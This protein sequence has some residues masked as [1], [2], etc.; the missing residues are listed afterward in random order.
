MKRIVLA[1]CLALW[2]VSAAGAPA[3]LLALSKRISIREGAD[4]AIVAAVIEHESR[5]NP[6]AVGDAGRSV[7][8]MAL[9]DAGVGRGMTVAERMDPETNIRTGARALVRYWDRYGTIEQTLAAYNAGV[10]ALAQ[11]G[12]DWQL[13]YG[14]RVARGYVLPVL[15]TAERYR[16]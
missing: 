2:P 16:E 8:L 3:D 14:G 12:D 9:H 13:V 11:A 4:P 5:W 1:L 6:R 15:A 7:G 10:G